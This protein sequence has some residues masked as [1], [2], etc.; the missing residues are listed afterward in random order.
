MET[1]TQR[2]HWTPAGKAAL[3]GRFARAGIAW[4]T[5]KTLTDLEVA[6]GRTLHHEY[7]QCSPAQKQDPATLAAMHDLYFVTDGLTGRPLEPLATR[8]RRLQEA[9][10]KL[11]TLLG[12][13][14]G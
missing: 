10:Q 3:R 12:L 14:V 13:T 6:I 1:Q 9:E 8:R 7:H 4:Q 5:I 2:I 11:L